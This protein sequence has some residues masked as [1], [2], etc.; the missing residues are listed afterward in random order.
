[1]ETRG[2]TFRKLKENC[3]YRARV[4]VDDKKRVSYCVHDDAAADYSD[5]CR[6]NNCPVWAKLRRGDDDLH[7]K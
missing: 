5:I 2:I 4:W 1:M 3:L 7:K 6:Q